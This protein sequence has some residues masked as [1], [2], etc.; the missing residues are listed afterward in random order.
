MA[1]F[2]QHIFSANPVKKWQ[3]KP[4]VSLCPGDFII[5]KRGKYQTYCAK[6]T[7]L[8]CLYYSF[9][10]VVNTRPRVKIPRRACLLRLSFRL[11]KI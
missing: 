5:Y 8:S 4:P 6:N 2:W 11:L 7:P 3:K 10:P 9:V 1:A